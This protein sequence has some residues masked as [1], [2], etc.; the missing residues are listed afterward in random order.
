MRSSSIAP[1][2]PSLHK[3]K[4]L[5]GTRGHS[6]TCTSIC[7]SPPTTLVSTLRSGWRAR[8][9]ADDSPEPLSDA[10]RE[11]SSVSCVSRPSSCS[12]TRLSPAWATTKL[13]PVNSAATTVVPMPL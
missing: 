8:A 1:W 5:P 6:E 12:Y 3:S 10:T 7:S 4:R 13:A 2:T 9:S 11:S